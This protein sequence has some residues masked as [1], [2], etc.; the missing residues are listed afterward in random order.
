MRFKISIL[1][2][3]LALVGCSSNPV[4]VSETAK[5]KDH[6][7][8]YAKVKFIS[9]CRK[10]AVDFSCIQKNYNGAYCIDYGVTACGE[11]F[12][13]TRIGRSWL[14]THSEKLDQEQSENSLSQSIEASIQVS[15]IQSANAASQVAQ[16]ANAASQAAQAASQAAQA[17]SQAAQAA[18]TP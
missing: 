17:A 8:I 1:F 2:S 10:E 4:S 14:I 9:D 3:A 15:N 6:R 13:F 16:T 5:S 7:E 11:K 18:I 12:I